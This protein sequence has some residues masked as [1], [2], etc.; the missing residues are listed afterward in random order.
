MLGALASASR[1]IRFVL[2]STALR[3]RLRRH[4]VRVEVGTGGGLRFATLP[5]VELDAFGARRG[6]TLTL[7]LGRDV[8]LGR[9]LTLDVRTGGD[10]LLEVGDGT[11]FQ[12]WGR[13]QL[14]GGTIRLGEHVHVRDLVQLKTKSTLVVGDRSVL[15]RGVAVHATAGVE[16]GA[17]CGIGERASLIDSDHE[18]DGSGGAFLQAPLRAEPIVLGRGVAISAGCVLLKGTRMG[19]GAALA[20]NAVISGAEVPAGGLFGGVPARPLRAPGTPER[21]AGGGS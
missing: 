19:D 12:S 5:H 20:A 21:E 8:R 14:H 1:R 11:T 15:S 3:A 9:G 17:D 16:M 18:L 6:G 2:W 4:G 13:V 7:R 10:N